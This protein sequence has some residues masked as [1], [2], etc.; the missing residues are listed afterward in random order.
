MSFLIAMIANKADINCDKKHE[1]E[2]LNKGDQNLH[3]IKR[4]RYDPS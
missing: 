3:E 2:C 4:K 1:D